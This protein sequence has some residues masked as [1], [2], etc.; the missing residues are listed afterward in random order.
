[1]IL[2]TDL[3]C[4]IGCVRQNNEDIILLN[5]DLFRNKSQKRVFELSAKARF[6][7]IVADGMGGHN[8]GE[9]ASEIAAQKF[10]EFLLNLPGGLGEADITLQLKN[11]AEETHHF[12]VSKSYDLP[13]CVGM[14]TTFCGIVFYESFVF[15]INI[16]DS[17]LYRFRGGI[18]KQLTSDHSMRELTGDMSYPSGQIYNSLGAGNSAFA[19]TMNITGQVLDEDTFLVCSDGLSDMLDNETIEQILSSDPTAVKLVSAAQKAGGHD[20]ISVILLYIAD[21]KPIG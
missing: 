1:M 3:S 21:E 2:K 11:W 16:G 10:D 12:M 9:Y 14:G 13:D 4:D 5:G 6:S 8:G 15:A 18:L 17:R 19:D 20:N 7:A